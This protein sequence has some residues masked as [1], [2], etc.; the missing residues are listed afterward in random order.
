MAKYKCPTLGDCDRANAAEIFERAPGQDLKCPG[1]NVLLEPQVASTRRNAASK[2]PLIAGAG[3][4][5]LALAGAWAYFHFGAG[6]PAS[7]PVVADNAPSPAMTPA[8]APAVAANGGTGIAPSDAENK[9]LRVQSDAQ[10]AAGKAAE[11]ESL[12]SKAA[13]NEMLKLAIAKMAQGKLDEAEKVLDEARAHAPKQPLVFYNLAIL[14]LK[15]GRVEDAMK[16]FENSFAAGFPYF[17]KLD[18]DSDLDALRKNPQFVEL[19]HKYR[20]AAK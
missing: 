16:Q 9:E 5:A 20:P 17:D 10:L 13:A 15:Q 4:L 8:P 18:Q 11:A 19:L 1:C 2:A 7:A 12:S 6:H 14:R 3:A